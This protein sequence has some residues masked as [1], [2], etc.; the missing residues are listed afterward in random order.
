MENKV[1]PVAEMLPDETFRFARKDPDKISRLEQSIRLSGLLEPIW[2][3]ESIKGM[4]ITAGFSRLDA[5]RA[6]GLKQIPV[7]IADDDIS[8]G[9]LL[10]QILLAHCVSSDLNVIEKARI[11][12]IMDSVDPENRKQL[13]TLLELPDKS[14]FEDEMKALLSLEPGIQ[15]YIEEYNVSFKQA[16]QFLQ[17]DAEEQQYCAELA[18]TL[19][20]RP[21]ELLDISIQL[22]E[23]AKRDEVSMQDLSSALGIPDILHSSLTRGQKIQE[24]KHQIAECRY[25]KLTEWNAAIEASAKSMGFPANGQLKWDK[26]LENPGLLIQMQLKSNEDVQRLVTDLSSDQAKTEFKKLFDT[27][28]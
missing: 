5:A 16:S 6:A 11:L 4:Q 7:F 3:K 12:K 21:V 13:F 22:R 28:S 23:S 2:V 1:I 24:L 17:L 18:S 15:Y 10:Y 14:S 8:I 20:I 26:T 27:L 9:Y 19:L 25:P